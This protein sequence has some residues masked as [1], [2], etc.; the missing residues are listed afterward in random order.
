MAYSGNKGFTRIMKATQ[1]SWQGL[2]AAYRHEEAFRQELWLSIVLIPLGFWLGQ[3][4]IER[5]LL[6]GSVI[7]LLLVEILNSA[8]EAVVDRIGDEQHELSGRA[9]DMGSA[10]VAIS[11]GLIVVVWTLVLLDHA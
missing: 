3:T 8:I 1:Y 10:A 9:K 6:T 5:A 4:G 11:I 2:R 7:M